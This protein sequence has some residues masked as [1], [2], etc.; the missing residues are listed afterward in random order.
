[1]TTAHVGLIEEASRLVPPCETLLLLATANVDKA[2]SGLPLEI[3]LDLLLR[4]ADPRPAVSVGVV[5]HGRFADKLEAIR[6]V[7]PDATRVVFLLGFD[8]LTRLFDPKYYD[9]LETC[10]ARLFRWSEC[11]VAHRGSDGP[12]AVEAFLA[13]GD[14]A[15]F[16]HRIHL[17]RLPTHLAAVSATDVRTRLATGEPIAGLVP[18]EIRSPLVTWWHD[19][20]Q[21]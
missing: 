2:V 17:I 16:A 11:V 9:D 5:A 13:R 14:I 10:L 1:M 19:H 8:T 15:R 6:G 7:Y 12:S 21:A 20:C 4:Y 3:R 18:S